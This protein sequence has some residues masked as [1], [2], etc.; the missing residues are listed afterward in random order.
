ML[1]IAWSESFCYPLPE[2]HRFPME[3][4]QLIPEQLLYEGT[5]KLE[6]LFQPEE[7]R[8]E[9]ILTAHSPE[10]WDKL[11]NGKLT[12]KEIRKIG[13]PYTPMLIKREREIMQG[14]IECALHALRYGVSINVAGGTHHA[15]RNSGEGFCLM[16]DFAI[17]ACYLLKM[18]LARKIMIIDL[19]VHQGNGTA[20]IF[21]NIPEVFTFSMHCSANYPLVKEP[22]DLDV[23]LPPGTDDKV[24]LKTLYDTLPSII[25]DF[26]PDFVCYLS[27]VDILHTDK[28]GKFGCT[29]LG[30]KARDE[31]VLNYCYKNQL[32]IAI[33][34]GGG[35]SHRIK[36]IIEAHCNTFRLAQHIWF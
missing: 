2:G 29:L 15:Y 12:P 35:Y 23:A 5:I 4:Y 14:T 22:S 13:F 17:A 18:K 26:Q 8:V 21:R 25:E 20:S 16:N 33:A 24:F 27:G 11:E 9:N 1:K 6:N 19:D 7:I 3:K 30:A 10:Y 36:D 28:L 32:P 34:M 31:Y